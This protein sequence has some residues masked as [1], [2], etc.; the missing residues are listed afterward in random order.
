MR[1][2]GE[3]AWLVGRLPLSQVAR[4][5]RAHR[6]EEDES[7]KPAKWRWYQRSVGKTVVVVSESMMVMVLEEAKGR[8][9]AH[10]PKVASDGAGDQQHQTHGP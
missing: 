1:T 8:Q 3:V 9:F 10:P 7:K 2:M 4:A 6:V 5:S